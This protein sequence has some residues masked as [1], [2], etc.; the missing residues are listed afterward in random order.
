[1]SKLI[2]LTNQDFGYWHV[3]E[4]APNNKEGQAMWLCKCTLCGK[5]IKTV[6]G[7]HLRS[8]RSTC[9]GCNKIE[10]MRLANIKDRTG[11]TYGFLYVNRLAN[12][13][14]LELQRKRDGTYWNCTCL[15]CGR[16]NVIVFGDYLENGDTKSCGCLTSLNESKI[17]QMLNT[18]NFQYKQQYSFQ[19]LFSNRECDKL[20]YDFAIF[21]NETLLYL[22]EYDGIQHFEKNH[23]HNNFDITR[24]NDLLKNKYCFS[25]NIPI[26][27]IPYNKPYDIND[28]KLETTKFLLTPEN[29]KEY[30]REEKDIYEISN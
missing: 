24:K 30:Y 21:N 13:Q 1:M 15:K 4:R 29:E 20:Y 25:N 2:D 14:E 28:L 18:L 9:C 19:D 11:K 23:F 17:A 8:G 26:I 6:S 16:K 7:G 12:A 10:K 5:T 22:I 27:R 3:L